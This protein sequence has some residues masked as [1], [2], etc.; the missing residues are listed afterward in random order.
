M[1]AEPAHERADISDRG[2]INWPSSTRRPRATLLSGG[3]LRVALAPAVVR[4]RALAR[5]R[6]RAR[7]LPHVCVPACACSVACPP[8]AA[9][10]RSRVRV[11]VHVLGPSGIVVAVLARCWQAPYIGYDEPIVELSTRRCHNQLLGHESADITTACVLWTYI[12]HRQHD[13]PSAGLA[14]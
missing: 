1:V 3:G 12:Y 7:S 6:A 5:D 8:W 4:A 10:A 11:R 14:A 13:G 2:P 9:C